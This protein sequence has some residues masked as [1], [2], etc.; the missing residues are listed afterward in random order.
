MTHPTGMDL[1]DHFLAPVHG[2]GIYQRWTSGTHLCCPYASTT[3][4]G[5][6]QL[7]LQGHHC[8]TSSTLVLV[9]STTPCSTFPRETPQG[10]ALC[11]ITFA[12]EQGSVTKSLSHMIT[13]GARLPPPVGFPWLQG[14]LSSQA[15]LSRP[16]PYVPTSRHSLMDRISV[17][18]GAIQASSNNSF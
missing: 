18:E 5:M 3:L 6:V 17:Q 12:C 15:F 16:P 8:Q 4:P 1:V 11:K 14:W 2:Q 13:H 9:S 7:S 10:K